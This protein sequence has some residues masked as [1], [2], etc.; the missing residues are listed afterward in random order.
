MGG[1]QAIDFMALSRDGRRI[2]TSSFRFFLPRLN[3]QD[4]LRLCEA[5]H[6][7][8]EDDGLRYAQRHPT[9]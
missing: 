4:G 1:L 7:A 8:P 2:H 6:P 3:A 5:H 9:Q